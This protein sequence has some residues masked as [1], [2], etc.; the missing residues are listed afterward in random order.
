MK[1]YFILFYLS[2][3][4]VLPFF[5]LPA[6]TGFAEEK[7]QY[8]MEKIFYLSTSGERKAIVDIKNNADK[9]DILAPQS[10]A[11]GSDLIIH[12]SLS[13]DLQDAILKSG[14]RVMPLIV[15]AGFSQPIIHKFLLSDSAQDKV[16]NALVYLAKKDNYIGWQFDFENI[17]FL[18][19][20]LYSA[21]V[22]K[23]AKVLH[24]NNLILS[25]A[26]V[27][28]TADYEN[29][30]AYRNWGGAFDYK[31]LADA[32]DF[33]SLMTYDDSKSYGPA[34]SALFTK[35][36]L[37]Y[38]KDKIPP[39][40]LSMGIP[41]YY[42]G[43]NQYPL[44][45][46]SS[47]GYNLVDLTIKNFV[48]RQGFDEGLGVPWLTYS[49]GKKSYKIWYEDQRSFGIKLDIVKDNNLRGFSAWVL[50]QEDPKIWS[51]LTPDILKAS[52]QQ[53]GY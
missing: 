15:N 31:R 47:G 51:V 26:A 50:G 22:E 46:V 11:V 16:I 1:K 23:T 3:F 14:V 7:P 43:W 17:N 38:V 13:A 44:K 40:K 34:S 18:D 2:A 52:L 28:R 45:R 4:V 29:T 42:W 10:Y 37:S 9:I 27:S 39:E 21:F 36:V 12:G 41:F 32:T 48:C 49:T 24:Q 20:D 19:R 8:N 6:Q 25:I 35:L 5:C 30:S 33:I 53:K